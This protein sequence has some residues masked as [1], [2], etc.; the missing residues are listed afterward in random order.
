MKVNANS[1]LID[2]RAYDLRSML[3]DDTSL[4]GKINEENKKSEIHGNYKIYEG[5]ILILKIN[6]DYIAEIQKD[7]GLS[8]NLEDDLNISKNIAGIEAIIIPKSR[9]IGRKYNYF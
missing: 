6:P 4:I 1:P 3:D 8:L 5:Q 7:F 2:K 9:L